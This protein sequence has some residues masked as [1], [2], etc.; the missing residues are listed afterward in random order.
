MIARIATRSI[1]DGTVRGSADGVLLHVWLSAVMERRGCYSAAA[2]AGPAQGRWHGSLGWVA[3]G[4]SAGAHVVAAVGADAL[5]GAVMTLCWRTVTKT[6]AVAVVARTGYG[7]VAAGTSSGHA[8]AAAVASSPV[9][10]AGVPWTLQF[11]LLVGYP[12]WCCSG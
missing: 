4:R 5:V 8:S 9:S 2:A 11:G 12:C 10:S 1:I 3:E 6:A 7:T